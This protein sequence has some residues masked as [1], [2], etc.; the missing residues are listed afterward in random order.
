MVDVES[1]GPIPHKY[2]MVCFGAVVLETSLTKKFYGQIKP[3]SGKWIPEA[4]AVS[5][6]TRQQH[7]QFEEPEA[8][9]KSFAEWLRAN[10]KGRPIFISDNLA[11]DWQW[12][13]YYFH[14]FVGENP[15]GFSGRRI[16]DLYC[17]M[18]MDT[19]LNREWK[20]RFRKTHHDH[21]PV[22]DALGNAEALLEMKKMGLKIP[23]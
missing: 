8:V 18:K 7:E 15:F 3:V 9:M 16:G 10:V 20:E 1:D 4:L 12:I 23:S 5:G 17:G 13:N 22:N 11:F 6:F 14:Y 19:G 21:H 2:S